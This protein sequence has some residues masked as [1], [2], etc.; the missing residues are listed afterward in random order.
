MNNVFS[1][2]EYQ[3]LQLLNNTINYTNDL[4]DMVYYF[5]KVWNNDG[6][7]T[8]QTRHRST[9]EILNIV[10]IDATVKGALDYMLCEYRRL[11]DIYYK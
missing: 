5:Q 8:I 10:V 11:C 1:P 2:H 4:P 7:V 6:K 9:H 3:N